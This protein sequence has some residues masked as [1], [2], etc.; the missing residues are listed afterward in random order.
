MSCLR[1]QREAGVRNKW[2]GRAWR[3]DDIGHV[4]LSSLDILFC[5][6]FP[7]DLRPVL[8]LMANSDVLTRLSSSDSRRGPSVGY[9]SAQ[10]GQ[11]QWQWQ[12][13]SFLVSPRLVPHITSSSPSFSSHHRH[14]P[15]DQGCQRASKRLIDDNPTHHPSLPSSASK[16]STSR[17]AARQ[18]YLTCLRVPRAAAK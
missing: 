13:P 10:A 7:A 8:L 17:S 5:L 3:W 2:K 16:P 14:P 4:V 12:C 1:G 11:W 18:P 9:T 6:F 15:P